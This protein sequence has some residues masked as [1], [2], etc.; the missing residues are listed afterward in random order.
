[1]SKLKRL[2]GA[3]KYFAQNDQ[4]EIVTCIWYDPILII[5]TQHVLKSPALII[6]NPLAAIYLLSTH[7]QKVKA[8]SYVTLK[9]KL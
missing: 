4:C 7:D 3:L 5:G 6:A 8:F 2:R 1:M 9:Y